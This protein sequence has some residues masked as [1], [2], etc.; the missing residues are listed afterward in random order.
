M[1][2]N[3]LTFVEPDSADL[4]VE[5]RR[6]VEEYAASLD[7]DLCFQDFAREL[8]TLSTQ[9]GPPDGC[10]L[11]AS[12]NGTF[13]GCGAI[14]PWEDGACEMKRLYVAPGHRG[15]GIGEALARDLV[16]RARQLGYTSVLLDTLPSMQAALHIYATLGF[17]PAR[18]YRRNPVPGATFLEL[19]LTPI[20]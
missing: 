2:H 5:A 11:L 4:W 8:E 14:R 18:P 15:K 7:F 12:W 19:G 1:G 10:F 20:A 17:V 9:Y 13:V 3:V 6:L 16:A